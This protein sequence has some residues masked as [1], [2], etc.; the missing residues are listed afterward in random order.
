MAPALSSIELSFK[1]KFYSVVFNFRACDKYLDPSYPIE[2]LAKFKWVNILFFNKY[3]ANFL[4][5]WSP[6]LLW[7][8]LSY[9]SVVLSI[10]PGEINLNRSS[11]IR[12]PERLKEI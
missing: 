12:L 2:L 3:L 11:S 1:L 9:T 4:A 6:I 5:P 8:R 7:A 10:S